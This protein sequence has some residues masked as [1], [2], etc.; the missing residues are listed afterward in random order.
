MKTRI[1]VI[2]VISLIFNIMLVSLGTLFILK[3]GLFSYLKQKLFSV[4]NN[5]V[6]Y[7]PYYLRKKSLFEILPSTDSQIIFMGDS[8]TEECEWAELLQNPSIKKR[9]I[10]GDTTDGILNRLDEVVETKPKKIFLMVGV[11]DLI[12]STKSV[13]EIAA[14]YQQIL[15]E[16]KT[17]SPN[18]KVFIQ[19]ILPVNNSQAFWIDNRRVLELNLQL[20]RLAH[21][22]SFQYI[23]LILHLSDSHEQLDARYTSDGLHLNGHAY[24]VWKEAIK[25]Y[26]FDPE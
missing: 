16:V 8:I 22:L 21:E 3:K 17:K 25:K 5:K 14:N 18:T 20:I 15:L 23:D 24:L 13:Q 26:V 4:L 9:G 7:S 11:N 12:H 1:A 19:S 2:L 6:D 10:S